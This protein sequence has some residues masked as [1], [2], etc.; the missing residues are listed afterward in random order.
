MKISGA[1]FARLVIVSMASGVLLAGMVTMQGS[2]GGFLFQIFIGYLLGRV[3]H[4]AADYKF[5]PKI[6]PIAVGACLLG[7]LLNHHI[8]LLLLLILY[9]PQSAGF[10][11]GHYLTGILLGFVGICIPLLTTVRTR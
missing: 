1:V 5:G 9:V 3:I 10:L 6:A 11:A 8:S 4:R 7:M 2:F